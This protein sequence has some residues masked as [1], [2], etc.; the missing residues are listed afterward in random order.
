MTVENAGAGGES[1]MDVP[2]TTGCTAG[3]ECVEG[4]CSFRCSDTYPGELGQDQ[5][6]CAAMG[7]TCEGAADGQLICTPL[8]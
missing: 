3:L 7:G 8:R 2:A 6:R 5:A 4:V 1:V